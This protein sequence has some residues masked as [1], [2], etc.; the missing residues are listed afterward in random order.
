MTNSNE[1]KWLFEQVSLA[2]KNLENLPVWVK[3][4]ARFEGND[5]RSFVA[6]WNDSQTSR[7]ES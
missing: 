6:K 3:K 7:E 1:K 4:A 2:K 5:S